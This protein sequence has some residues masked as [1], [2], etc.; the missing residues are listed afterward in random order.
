MHPTVRTTSSP[1]IAVGVS[2]V[3][4]EL[5]ANSG[6]SLDAQRDL[7]SEL[8]Q[9]FDC[10]VEHFI[11]DDGYSGDDFINRPSIRRIDELATEGKIGAVV[12]PHLDRFARNV[13]KG[14]AQIRHYHEDLGLQVLLG[15]LGWYTGERNFKTQMTIGLLFAEITK[16]EIAEKS[17]K[18]VR[19]KVM[20]G[21]PQGGGAPYA[22]RFVTKGELVADAIRRGEEKPKRP[23]NAFARIESQA[24]V[25]AQIYAWADEGLSLRGICRELMAAGIPPARTHWNPVTISKILSEE[26]YTTGVWHYNKRKGTEPE[27]PRNKGPR[28]RRKSSWQLRPRNEWMPIALPGGPLIDKAMFDRVQV[29]LG[30]NKSL[31]AKP[32]AQRFMLSSLVK[33]TICGYSCCG[34]TRTSKNRYY[35][36]SNRDRTHGHHLCAQKSVRAE[37]LDQAVWD[38]LFDVIT[39][40]EMLRARVEEHRAA[41]VGQANTGEMEST[42][43]R[44]KKLREQM[45]LAAIRELEEEDAGLRATY[46]QRIEEL[47]DQVKFLEKRLAMMQ[48]AIQRFDIDVDTIVERARAARRATDPGDRRAIVLDWVEAVH[49]ADQTAEILVRVPLASG[50]SCKQEERAVDS[51]PS[52]SIKLIRRVA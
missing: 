15:N 27:K 25:I 47:R 24:V 12:F 14:L 8:G 45:S 2:R 19:I 32:E 37:L 44:T 1:L 49:Y 35:T 18:G 5:Q 34:V 26:A 38:E 36:C 30:K 33:C 10:N 43:A 3:S 23:G 29:Q 42:Q 7:F 17:R 31:L 51:C 48:R 13:E 21:K 20:Q 39:E 52:I 11:E 46:K 50:G 22:Y 9:K 28:H 41:I 4:L 16:D 6:Y 40:P